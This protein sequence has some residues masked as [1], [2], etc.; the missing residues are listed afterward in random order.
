MD[1]KQFF[2]YES[3][4]Y[5]NG[6]PRRLKTWPVHLV[7]IAPG[8]KQMMYHDE[9]TAMLAAEKA[10]KDAHR[11]ARELELAATRP[12]PAALSTDSGSSLPSAS[13]PSASLP[14]SL[15]PPD[16][17]RHSRRCLVCSHPDRD[18]IEGEFIRWRSPHKIARDYNVSDRASI[19][20]HAH[21][22][23]LFEA[24]RR[25]IGRVLE[26]YLETVGDNPPA[27]FDPVTRAVR[28][29]AH[30]D[31]NGAWVEPSRTVRIITSCAPWPSPAE[32]PD[33]PP[34]PAEDAALE[35]IENSGPTHA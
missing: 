19:Y 29:Y 1:Y 18:A 24:R 14:P 9:Y 25:H 34:D 8:Q 6:A 22:T 5:P 4:P 21:A 3:T 17:E 30:L 13:L 2:Q 7:N 31:A 20:R 26:S 28:V 12:D 15:L 11:A 27:D 32:M 23:G 16:L 35:L 10:A 33:A